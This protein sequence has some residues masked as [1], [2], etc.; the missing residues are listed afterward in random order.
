MSVLGTKV[1]NSCT[2]GPSR[3]LYELA[4]EDTPQEVVQA[5]VARAEE[6]E[7]VSHAEV[8]RLIAEAKEAASSESKKEIEDRPDRMRTALQAA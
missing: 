4:K 8:K 3:A 5:V 6:G 1:C 2:L 7:K